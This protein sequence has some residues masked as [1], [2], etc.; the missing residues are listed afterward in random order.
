MLTTGSPGPEKVSPY[1][2]RLYLIERSDVVHKYSMVSWIWYKDKGCEA[3][4]YILQQIACLFRE[5]G[6]KFV[7]YTDIYRSLSREFGNS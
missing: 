2:C 7:K 4:G 6:R 1:A 3:W 5:L